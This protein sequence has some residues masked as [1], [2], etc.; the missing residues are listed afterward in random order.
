[1][2]FFIVIFNFCILNHIVLSN[3]IKNTDVIFY[4]DPFFEGIYE[5]NF[6]YSSYVNFVKIYLKKLNFT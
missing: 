1:M 2:N 6:F 3:L 5:Q 4:E